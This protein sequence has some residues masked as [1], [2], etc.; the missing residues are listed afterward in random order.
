VL[1][2]IY[3][4]GQPVWRKFT[5][6][7][8]WL[9]RL[10]TIVFVQQLVVAG[11]VIF[12]VERISDL[13]IFAA[14]LLDLRAYYGAPSPEITTMACVLTA[15]WLGQFVH[16][17]LPFVDVVR[18]RAWNPWAM[19]FLLL[20]SLLIVTFKQPMPMPFIYFKF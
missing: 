9:N 4:V 10:L 7:P 14:R 11:W 20:M 13:R 3:R 2:V 5:V 1:L 17:K 16:Q 18:S 19:S 15:I 8:Q 6:L 12:C